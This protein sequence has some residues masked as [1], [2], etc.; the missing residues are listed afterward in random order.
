VK[1]Q[2]RVFF[3]NS[4]LFYYYSPG[5][6]FCMRENRGGCWTCKEVEEGESCCGLEEKHGRW[7][8]SAPFLFFFFCRKSERKMLR[9]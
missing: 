9:A 6:A 7:R 4:L 2:G 8:V 1:L 5:F 3:V